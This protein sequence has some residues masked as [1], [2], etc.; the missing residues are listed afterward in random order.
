MSNRFD[1]YVYNKKDLFIPFIVAGD[2]SQEMTVEIAL[3]LQSAGADAIEI[4]VPYSDPLADGP[5]IQAASARA[6]RDEMTLE[7]AIK[8][9][10]KM[11]RKGLKIPVVIFTYYNLLLQLGTERFFSLMEA[12]SVDGL[13]VPDLPFEESDELR[14]EC[15]VKQI[16]YISIVTP[17][18]SAQRLQNIVTNA[19]GF[20]YCVSSLGVTGVR[21]EFH[22]SVYTFLEDVKRHA[23]VPVA[24][25]FG[26]SQPNQVEHLKE[27][28]DGVIIGSAIVRQI[29]DREDQLL[30]PETKERA[31][32]EIYEFAYS[33]LAPY[34]LK[35]EV[36]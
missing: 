4:G 29:G 30:N 22:P 8:L 13:L 35:E 36:E 34:R 9:V 15:E 33:L 19:E 17:T 7:T 1:Q 10:P 28:C 16:A 12:N 5:V 6:L 21:N 23:T 31:L 32:A 14:A 26:I 27:H 2:P 11:R 18:T 20:L 25:G 3:T 24:V